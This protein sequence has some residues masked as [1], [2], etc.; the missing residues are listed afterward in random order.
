MPLIITRCPLIDTDRITLD[1]NSID[2]SARWVNPLK[3]F[4]RAFAKFGKTA[5]ENGH[6]DPFNRAN[7]SIPVDR[8]RC[9]LSESVWTTEY[10]NYRGINAIKKQ[11][12]FMN[13]LIK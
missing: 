10:M 9:P 13:Q 5:I 11:S 8:Q 2:V 3:R 4:S 6:R 1:L 12:H 7:Q